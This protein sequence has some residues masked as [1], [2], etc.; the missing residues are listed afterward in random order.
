MPFAT[1]KF[2][3]IESVDSWYS[4]YCVRCHKI[5]RIIALFGIE[6]VSEVLN[7]VL[8]VDADS[9][10]TKVKSLLKEELSERVSQFIRKKEKKIEK[11]ETIDETKEENDENNKLTK[12]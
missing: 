2:C 1:C 3:E 9:Q 5:K 12:M 6:K 11:L 7:T 10:K 8:L 4:S